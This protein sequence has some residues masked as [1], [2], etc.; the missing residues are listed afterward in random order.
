MKHHKILSN[1][2]RILAEMWVGYRFNHKIH[3]YVYIDLKEEGAKDI[4]FRLLCD[5]SLDLMVA[6]LGVDKEKIYCVLEKALLKKYEIKTE[7]NGVANPHVNIQH[8]GQPQE[9][10]T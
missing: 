9:G 2:G 10:E 4:I 5:E 7:R 8:S 3:Q 1:V 6:E